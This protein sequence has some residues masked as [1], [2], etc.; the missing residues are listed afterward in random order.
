MYSTQ[1]GIFDRKGTQIYANNLWAPEA[2]WWD[3][4]VLREFE[5]GAGSGAYSPV[6]N[7]FN[8]TTGNADRIYTLYNEDGG[9][10]QAYGGRAAFWGDFFGDWR[11]E[12]MVVAN[13]YN[14]VRIYTTK[15]QATNRIYC[16]MQNPHV[17]RAKHLSRVITRRATWITTS[18]TTCPPCP[19][20]PFPTRHSS[21]GAALPALGIT[22]LPTGSPTTSGSPILPP[23][24]LPSVTSSLFDASGS[25][26]AP[27][28]ISGTLTPSAV[29][30]HAPKELHLRQHRWRPDRHDEVD[31]SRRGQTHAANG[32]NTY[33]GATL[34]GEGFVQS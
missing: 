10:H 16:L 19:S 25:N 15:I 8:P 18:A 33:T 32:T 7:K 27:I 11:E 21:G 9:V 31:Q 20:R 5:D 14:S 1:P 29:R 28:T 2:I 4:D 26:T 13:D 24:R 17:S 3:A 23:S 34:I 30:V 22:P 12:F 6:I